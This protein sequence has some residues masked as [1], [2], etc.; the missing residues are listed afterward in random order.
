MTILKCIPR[1]AIVPE[2]FPHA[3]HANTLPD[4][5]CCELRREFPPIESFVRG[6]DLPSNFKCRRTAMNLLADKSL[7]PAWRKFIEQHLTPATLTDLLQ[8][9]GDDIRREFPEFESRFGHFDLLRPGVRGRDQF[10]DHDV[11]LDAQLV[12][13]MPVV[14]GPQF[15]RR[16]HVKRGNKVFELQL[17]LPLEQ[18][19][20]VGAEIEIYEVRP[21]FQPTF[22]I[23]R[24]TSHEF[25]R[26]AHWAPHRANTALLLL[27]TSR[28]IT[29]IALR[30]PSPHPMRYFSLLA[31]FPS[32]IFTLPDITDLPRPAC[33]NRS[34][35]IPAPW[36]RQTAN[37]LRQRMA[38]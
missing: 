1:S 35:T 32:D 18:D 25:L 30:G 31:E 14:G 38:G 20:P 9:L 36:W 37:K 6:R 24:Q 27:N 5:L 29:Q 19:Q 33:L 7:S 21:G 23:G 4:E 17:Y 2:P 26:L 12:A 10:G 28:S 16:P 3:L 13:H 22:E 15:E 8:L 34:P 11:L